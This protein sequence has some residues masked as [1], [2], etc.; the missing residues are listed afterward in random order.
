[1][2]PQGS[3][4]LQFNLSGLGCWLTVLG[5][6]WLLGAIGLGWLVKSIAL[7]LVLLLVAPVIGFLGFRWWLNRNLVEGNC[8]VCQAPLTGLNNLNTACPNCQTSLQVTR[9]GF[10]RSTPEGTVD[11][12]A[13]DITEGA[14][15][16]DDATEVTVEVLPP[17]DDDRP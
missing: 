11:V 2:Y 5:G 15:N 9:E 3:N 8:P 10:Q 12:S 4:N 13:V 7:L 16:R 14:A 1:M 6:A 17:V